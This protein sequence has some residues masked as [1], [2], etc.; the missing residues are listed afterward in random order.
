EQSTSDQLV[1][2]SDAGGDA[3]HRVDWLRRT[4]DVRLRVVA[5]EHSHPAAPDRHAVTAIQMGSVPE[6][7]DFEITPALQP[8]LGGRQ[9]D[10]A[11]DHRLFDA[12]A[13][14]AIRPVGD[15]RGEEAHGL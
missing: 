13:A 11:V 12:E 1:E 3:A 4:D 15:V 8:F 5:G 2:S 7:V 10:H 6:L 9:Q 14:D